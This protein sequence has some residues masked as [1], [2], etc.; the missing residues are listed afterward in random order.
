MYTKVERKRLETALRRIQR[1]GGDCIH[2]K[3]C[4]IYI[5]STCRA[6]YMACGCDILPQDMFSFIADT[7]GQLHTAALE[8]LQFE[9]SNVTRCGEYKQP[10]KP[11]ASGP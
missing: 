9:L 4:H 11:Q 7:P 3:K 6:I 8:T 10:S 2:C 5:A 1:C